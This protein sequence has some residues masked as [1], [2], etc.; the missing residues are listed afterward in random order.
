LT[1]VLPNQLTV[2]QQV[3]IEKI[4][5]TMS[6]GMT[7]MAGT[8]LALNIFLVGA[9]KFLWGLVNI[10]QFLVFMSRWK[11]DYPANTLSVLKFIKTIALME[12]MPTGWFTDILS[13]WFGIQKGDEQNIVENM[14]MMLLIGCCLL[15]AVLLTLVVGLL[16]LFNFKLYRLF[17]N[18]LR[19]VF[20]N[21]FIRYILQ[22]TLKLQIASLTTMTLTEWDKGKMQ[23]IVAGSVV[24]LLTLMPFVAIAILVKHFKNLSKPS[25]VDKIGS[26]YLGL[27]SD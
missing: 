23:I 7:I 9:L 4:E 18:L 3:K 24:V 11:L 20:Y 10:L 2:K 26:F 15:I 21:T 19:K 14:G 17:R 22:S 6:T 13:D 12:F 25:M 27:K 5:A 16:M 1:K 8:N